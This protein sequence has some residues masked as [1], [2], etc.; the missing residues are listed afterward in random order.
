MSS[1]PHACSL[2]SCECIPGCGFWCHTKDAISLVFATE[3]RRPFWMKHPDDFCHK[4][5]IDSITGCALVPR[6]NWFPL[7]RRDQCQHDSHHHHIQRESR[8]RSWQV[9]WC[10]EMHC[11]IWCSAICDAVSPSLG[12]RM[13]MVLWSTLLEKK[14]FEVKFIGIGSL[15]IL[16][17][18]MIKVEQTV[19]MML[20]V[21]MIYILWWVSVCLSRKI[22]TFLKDLS[23]TMK[24]M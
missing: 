24:V 15:R 5:V 19:M 18:I 9:S 4:L 21:L 1:F 7:W 17:K 13:L 8:C 6:L 22:I 3:G 23:V 16:N 14:L 12:S 20:M 10:I 11:E 2:H